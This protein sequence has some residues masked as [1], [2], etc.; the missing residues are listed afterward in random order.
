MTTSKAFALLGPTA[1]GKTA[2]ALRI[3]E[4]L[5]VEIIS[6]DSALVYRE[7]DIGTAKPSPEERA[8]VPHH[9]IDIISPAEAYNAAQFVEDCTRLVRE[10]HARGKL[11][12]IVGGTMMYFQALTQGLNHLPNADACVRADLSE[13]KDMY[14][15]EHLYRT[16]QQI[17][18]E[19]ACRLKPGDSQRIERALE[20]YYLTGRPM[21]ALLREQPGNHPDLDLHTA[22]LIPQARDKLHAHIALRFHKMLEQGFL[23]EVENL[24]RNYPRL[25][26][27][28]PSVRC[29]GYRQAWAYLD[30]ETDYPSFIEKGIAATRQ[31]AKRQ[32]TWL[33]KIPLDSVA[34]PYDDTAY[35]D[36][37]LDEAKRFFGY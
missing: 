9:L 32:L 10:I 3:A 20:V 5:P 37:I 1:G 11:P 14:G 25:T 18:P 35:T 27:D 34:D 4:T 29:V 13:Q 19:T 15:L 23:Q 31:L 24:R 36:K 7:M 33:R 22:A 28:T 17:D 16:L 2:L 26:A 30:G 6:L 12:L 21:S 8:Q